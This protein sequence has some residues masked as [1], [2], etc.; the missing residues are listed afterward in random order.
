MAI[1]FSSILILFLPAIL[2]FPGN[3][4]GRVQSL[5][6]FQRLSPAVMQGSCCCASKECRGEKHSTILWLG[7]SLN[8]PMPLDYD[9]HSCFSDFFLPL[10][11]Q[12][13]Y[14]GLVLL[15]GP[16]PGQIRLWSSSLP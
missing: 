4:Q 14:M 10:V 6:L 5:W 1:V 7:L 8:G 16:S 3:F 12:E 9:F 2:D 11:K 13:G 15:N